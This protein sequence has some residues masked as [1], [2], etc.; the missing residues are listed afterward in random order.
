M[1]GII[2]GF[3]AVVEQLHGMMRVENY[4]KER[5]LGFLE[6]NFQSGNGNWGK[7]IGNASQE[8]A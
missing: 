1:P 7:R 3:L 2:V 5:V 4:F 6:K 8:S